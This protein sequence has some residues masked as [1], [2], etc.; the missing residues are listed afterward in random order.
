MTRSAEK[1]KSRDTGNRGGDE[2]DDHGDAFDTM[3]GLHR[4]LRDQ[5]PVA[6][7]SDHDGAEHSR[8]TRAMHLTQPPALIVLSTVIP[9]LVAK[10]LNSKMLAVSAEAGRV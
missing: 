4:G 2:H 10:P 1:A 7:D 8:S 9:F 6:G 5:Q 3:H